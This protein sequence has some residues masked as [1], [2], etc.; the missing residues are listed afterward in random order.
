M[1]TEYTSNYYTGAY[2]PTVE[3]TYHKTLTLSRDNSEQSLVQL[4]IS[5][6]GGS[7]E[8][9]RLLPL[10][11]GVQGPIDVF[12]LCFKIGD[13]ESL[14][15]VA[16][17]W[18]EIVDHVGKDVP[19]IV[20]GLMSDEA[21]SGIDCS[22]IKDIVGASA[23]LECSALKRNGISEVF[24]AAATLGLNKRDEGKIEKKGNGGE[25]WIGILK[26]T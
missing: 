19:I 16:T 11:L 13:D 26:K 24:E 9:D 14:R 1:I 15:S 22:W 7:E 6:L 2:E 8:Y 21:L 10:V 12:I 23:Y 17:R 25:R 18:K 5:D 4:I 20:V 3:E